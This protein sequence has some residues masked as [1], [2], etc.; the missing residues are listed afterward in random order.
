MT[1]K[2]RT[3]TGSGKPGGTLVRCPSCGAKNR[4][5]SPN[6]KGRP[7]CGKCQAALPWIVDAKDSNFSQAIDTKRLVLV[8]LWAPW[9]G[10][11][12]TV[13]PILE[14]LAKE[15]AEKLKVVKVNVDSSPQVAQRYRASSIPML[16]FMK[17]GQVVET[18]LGAQPHRVLTAKVADHTR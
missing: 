17:Q 18:V 12:R 1:K 4:A 5:S 13:A 10:P 9:C 7:R 6:V 16:L 14:T 8:D 3:P 11:C 15:H 2:R